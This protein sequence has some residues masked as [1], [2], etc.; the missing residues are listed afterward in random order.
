MR[1]P[2][3]DVGKSFGDI[4]SPAAQASHVVTHLD[5]G[6]GSVERLRDSR[7][8]SLSAELF[9]GEEIELAGGAGVERWRVVM[10][11]DL[12]KPVLLK[13]RLA[14][15]GT[16]RVERLVGSMLANEL[17]VSSGEPMDRGDLE[18]LV[19]GTAW[20]L[21][22]VSRNGLLA[23]LEAESFD[24]DTVSEGVGLFAGAMRAAFGGDV[25]PNVIYYAMATRP[26]DEL[27]EELWGLESQQD[28]DIDAPDGWDLL[29]DASSVTVAILDSG[30]R[31]S[32]EDLKANLWLNSGEVAGNG[33]DDDRNGYVDDVHGINVIEGSGD[34]SD[35]YGHGTHVAGIVGAEG[36]NAIGTSGVAWRARMM[37]VKFLN[38]SGRGTLE[39]AVKAIDYAVDNGA[40][41]INASWGGEG[42]AA[43]L[44]RAMDRARVGGVA[45]VAAA[46]NEGLN[47][48]EVY[49][50]PA[51]STLANVISVASSTPDGTLSGFSNYGFETTDLVAPGDYVLSTWHSADDAYSYESGTSMAAPYVTGV[52]ALNLV[53]RPNDSLQLQLDR[54]VQSSRRRGDLFQRARSGGVVNLA[55]S[56]AMEEVPFPP[57]LIEHSEKVVAKLEGETA[58]FSAVVSS[59][60][61][62][63]F[64]WY[65]E[66]VELVG[67]TTR[68]WFW[69]RLPFW[70]GVAT[71]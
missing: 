8:W 64:R 46:G 32:H 12:G 31:L 71:S 53:L 1:L 56:L 25:E 13:E 14:S 67:E 5:G 60:L 37:A 7:D 2:S 62:V 65:Y 58:T 68:R 51:S 23:T 38:A 48:D 19:A 54:L 41:V 10:A 42:R 22:E 40:K 27:W 33:V 43:S 39:D 69:I 6:V 61:P 50:Y 34:P 30:V 17:V 21:D 45:I 11:E 52:L 24:L 28:N 16:G 55:L 18:R 9:A 15:D 59:E 49:S 47:N 4:A 29:S 44:E 70:T 26:D 35:D 66:D 20:R 57:V 36:N 63:S 3:S